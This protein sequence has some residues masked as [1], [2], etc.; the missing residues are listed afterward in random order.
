[1]SQAQ[2][3]ARMGHS[4]RTLQGVNL[5]L[6]SQGGFGNGHAR[7]HGHVMQAIRELNVA[8]SIR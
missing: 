4:L 8:L 2:S 7:A 3:D 6:A 5:Q 1:M